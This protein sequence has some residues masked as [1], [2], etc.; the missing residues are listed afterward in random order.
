MPTQD[1]LLQNIASD[2]AEMKTGMANMRT[3]MARKSDIARLDGNIDSLDGKV[4]SLEIKVEQG[5]QDVNE[6]IIHEVRDLSENLHEVM[7][8][9]PTTLKDHE[10]R[11]EVIAARVG[12]SH[13][14]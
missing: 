13:P 14:S 5:F 7:D 3:N 12:L 8:K 2:I 11:I 4:V 10:E 1:E 6:I 9:L